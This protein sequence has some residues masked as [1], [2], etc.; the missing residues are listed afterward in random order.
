MTED[1]SVVR[2][3]VDP[4]KMSCGNSPR[5]FS[6]QVRS[7]RYGPAAGRVRPRWNHGAEIDMDGIGV[8]DLAA[9]RHAE[10]ILGL[11]IGLQRREFGLCPSDGLQILDRVGIDGEEG[12][13]SRRTPKPYS[14]SWHDRGRSRRRHPGPKNSTNFPTTF[15]ARSALAPRSGRY[16]W[17][18]FQAPAYP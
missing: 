2:P 10:H 11:E 8:V 13:P 1:M 7:G 4:G 12:C 5:T 15:L 17:P 6:F 9:R 3:P 16:P 18:R 14:R